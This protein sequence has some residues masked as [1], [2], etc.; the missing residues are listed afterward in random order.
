MCVCVF[1]DAILIIFLSHSHEEKSLFRLREWMEPNDTVRGID[2]K[3]S[4]N[5]NSLDNTV[6]VC[7]FH[8]RP[9]SFWKI[10]SY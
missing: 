4:I 8:S 3:N 2:Y 7:P 5:P 6:Y 9:S 10:L 1:Y